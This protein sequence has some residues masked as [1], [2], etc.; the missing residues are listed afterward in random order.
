MD[1]LLLV[2]VSRGF[3]VLPWGMRQM[4]HCSF[5]N[6][7][8]K[9]ELTPTWE[10]ESS[11]EPLALKLPSRTAG[12][13]ALQREWER[14]KPSAVSRDVTE[15]NQTMLNWQTE[16]FSSRQ[17]S[18]NHFPPEA[19][20]RTAQFCEV[21]PSGWGDPLLDVSQFLY[22]MLRLLWFTQEPSAA[23]SLMPSQIFSSWP[24]LWRM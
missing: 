18:S 19:P 10:L 22:V 20:D 3:T 9:S 16:G 14:L 12:D 8:F 21:P 24:M 6:N 13:V 4:T 1:D 2:R 17:F 15:N 23:M 5:R 11:W 7:S